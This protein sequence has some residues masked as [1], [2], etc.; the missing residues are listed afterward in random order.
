MVTSEILVLVMHV[1]GLRK[2][3]LLISIGEMSGGH[4]QHCF[5]NGMPFFDG[6]MSTYPFMNWYLAC[7][8]LSYMTA[9][10]DLPENKPSIKCAFLAI[11]TGALVT[12]VCMFASNQFPLEAMGIIGLVHVWL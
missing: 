7:A 5:T 12:R 10:W 6:L 9:P 4:Y 1:F 2:A 11:V 8:V 3:S